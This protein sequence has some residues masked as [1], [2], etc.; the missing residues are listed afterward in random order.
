MA[1]C[2]PGQGTWG[3]LLMLPGA[4][5]FI[6]CCMSHIALLGCCAMQ[7]RLE[8]PSHCPFPEQRPASKEGASADCPMGTCGCSPTLCQLLQGVSE[9]GAFLSSSSPSF[10]LHEA[11]SGFSSL[12]QS[13]CHPLGAPWH[14]DGWDE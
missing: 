13:L 6:C 4:G 10:T 8:P 11:L 5:V 14:R 7:V 12:K 3:Q 9:A 2:G 1:V